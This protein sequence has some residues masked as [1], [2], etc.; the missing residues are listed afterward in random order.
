[1]AD[2][3][4]EKTE[5]LSQKKLDESRE[6]GELPRSQE[7]STF[8][9]F[10]I[11][12]AYFAM[13]RL[14]WFEGLAKIM[15]DLLSFDRYLALNRETISEFLLIPIGKAALI[16]LPLFG[17]IM[18]VSS[19]VN[20]GQT[21]FNMATKKLELNWGRMNPASGL[22]RMFSM[23]QWIE[24]LKSCI[25][26]GLFA[27]LAWRELYNALPQLGLA[28]A[29]DLYAQLEMMLALCISIGIRICILMAVLAVLDYAY[30]WWEFQKKL[31]MSFQ[32]MKDEAKER[33]GNPLIKQRQ[34]SLAMQQARNR[35]MSAVP[36]ASVVVTNPTH[37]AVALS[38][39]REKYN[40][41]FVCAKGKQ[42]LAQKIKEVARQH[43]VPVIENKPLA[44]ALYAQVK[45]G[46]IIP[47]DFYKAV[48]EVLAFVYLLK[49]KNS[50]SGR[51][52]TSPE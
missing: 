33:E 13:V 34:R 52:S 11:F 49:K 41:P 12:I 44:R 36:K 42:L 19:V 9:V 40:A 25:K 37:Y 31:R 38:Y 14:A 17:M 5:H 16:V 23:H 1:M 6:K 29:Q 46:Q 39:D 51:K 32:E 50:F 30:Q 28:A 7:L 21:G 35:M 2:N 3:D 48:A 27:W 20:S 45:L 24:G 47:N 22:K 18:L 4:Q 10:A 26:I 43:G 8:I 15:T